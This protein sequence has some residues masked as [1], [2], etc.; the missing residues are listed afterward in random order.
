ML[1][2]LLLDLLQVLDDLLECEHRKNDAE[3]VSVDL[4]ECEGALVWVCN[5]KTL[6]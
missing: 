5:I 4:Y 2:L 1:L 6:K 3:S